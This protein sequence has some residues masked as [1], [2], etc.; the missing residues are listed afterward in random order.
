MRLTSASVD[1]L[2]QGLG[3]FT[4]ISSTSMA[5]SSWPLTRPVSVLQA[6]PMRFR[7]SARGGPCTPTPDPTSG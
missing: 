3:A 5:F 4:L 7:R 6:M 2:I 1:T